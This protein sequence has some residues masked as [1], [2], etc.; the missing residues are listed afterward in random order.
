M[1][2]T[3]I[4]GLVV[5]SVFGC[6]LAGL[7]AEPL[8]DD[9]GSHTRKI[10]TNQTKAQRYFDQGIGIGRCQSVHMCRVRLTREAS[11]EQLLRV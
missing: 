2:R 9:L 10:T 4:A 3:R 5:L 11:S 7:A 1:K 6:A 8:F